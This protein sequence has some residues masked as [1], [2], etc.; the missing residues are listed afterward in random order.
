MFLRVYM[1]HLENAWLSIITLLLIQTNHHL[2]GV[3]NLVIYKVN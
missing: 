1:S 3:N 2:D